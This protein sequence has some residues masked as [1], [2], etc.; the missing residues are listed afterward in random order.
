VLVAHGQ[1]D[2]YSAPIFKTAFVDA[3]EDGM[4]DIVVDLSHVDFMDSTGLGVLVGVSR[5]L[6]L[7]GGSLAIVS[8]DPTIRRVF[9]IAGLDRRFEIFEQREEAV[10]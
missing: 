9:E 5:R 3:I 7:L 10:R 8:P 6:K 4:K 2:L 1:I